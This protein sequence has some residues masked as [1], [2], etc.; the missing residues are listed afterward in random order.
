MPRKAT[1]PPKVQH[2]K[3]SGQDRVRWKGQDIYLGPSGTDEARSAYARLVAELAAGRAP[4]PKGAGPP[5]TVREVVA[6][7]FGQEAPRL[8]ERGREAG[9]FRQAVAPLLALYG[10]TPAAEFDADRLEAVRRAMADGSWLSAEQ[11]ARRGTRYPKGL[12][13]NVVNRRVVRVRTV[14]RWAERKKLVP[15]G[16]WAALRA[17]PGLAPNDASVRQTAPVRPATWEETLAAARH[18]KPAVRAL[19]LLGWWSGARPGELRTM[20]PADLDRSGDVWVY[21]PREHKN[22]W[23]GQERA[24]P[25]GPK[26]QAVLRPFLAAA[27]GPD[28]Y[29]FPPSRRRK[30]PCYTEHTLAQAVRR[31]AERAGVEGLHFYRT[32]HAA[33]KRIT[34]AAGLEAARQVLGQKSLTTTDRYAAGADRQAAA[35]A[36]RKLA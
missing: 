30:S 36:A 14:W 18:C 5:R 19:L 11:L 7:W 26:C 25:L 4:T 23:R 24:V 6:A 2:H 31:A 15:P 8:S 34:G 10:P 33:K 22:D 12:C 16:S 32:R 9:Q 27:A 3:A 13:R 35:D 1:F 29:L 21:R 17:L 28:A 20:R